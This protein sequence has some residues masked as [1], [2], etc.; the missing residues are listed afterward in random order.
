MSDDQL[1]PTPEQIHQ[2]EQ[3]WAYAENALDQIL[4]SLRDDIPKVSQATGLSD[5]SIVFDYMQAF[6]MT[7]EKQGSNH[8][9]TVVMCAA[10]M[11]R[12]ARASRA[13]DELLTR[14]DKEINDNDEH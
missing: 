3:R 9:F 13:D 8:W 14:L 4:E 11:T 7:K 1:H 10:A 5:G 2:L 6:I 12:L